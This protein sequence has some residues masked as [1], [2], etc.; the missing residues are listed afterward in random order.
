MEGCTYAIFLEQVVPCAS[1][2][3]N[4]PISTHQGLPWDRKMVWSNVNTPTQSSDME[5]ALLQGL[6]GR[7]RTVEIW[8]LEREVALRRGILLI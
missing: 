6:L 3:A 4:G 8:T 2:V 5:V 1:L 7:R